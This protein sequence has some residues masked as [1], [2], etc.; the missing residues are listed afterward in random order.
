MKNKE[1]IKNNTKIFKCSAKKKGTNDGCVIKWC[2]KI[3]KMKI[4]RC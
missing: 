2:V 1:R 4:L 3:N